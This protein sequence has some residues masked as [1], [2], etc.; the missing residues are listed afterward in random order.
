MHIVPELTVST[1]L[2]LFVLGLL[3]GWLGA[4][5]GIGGGV[6]IV[7]SLVLIFGVDVKLAVATSLIAVIA[8]STAA[9]SV[10]VARGQTHTRLAIGLEVA[11]TVGGV[12]GSLVAVLLPS[13]VIAGV[14]AVVMGITAALMFGQSG[15]LRDRVADPTKNPEHVGEESGRLAGSYF[16]ATRGGVVRYEASHV[17]QGLGVSLLA[18]AVSGML[19]V[20]GGF[21][22]VP[23]MNLV[24]RVPIQVAV[25]TSA[26]MIGVTAAASVFVY[27]GKGLVIPLLAAP[28]VLGVISG[29]LLATRFSS[30]AHPV[31]IK[32]M[33][34]VVLLVVAVEM[35]LRAWGFS[36]VH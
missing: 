8:T 7:P 34:A 15:R 9:G 32:R 20:G 26:F 27:F 6:V 11:T 22:K 12:A 4:W 16:D 5:I 24:M 25:G 23:T 29:A 18:G 2:A 14:F 17:P 31:L 21:L 10:Y 36:L 1:L 33:L 28:V 35:G 13:Q 19:G 30:K 3:S